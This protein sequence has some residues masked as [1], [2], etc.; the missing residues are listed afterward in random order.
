MSAIKSLKLKD[1]DYIRPLF[2]KKMQKLI[3]CKEFSLLPN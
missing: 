3:L 2:K 1:L